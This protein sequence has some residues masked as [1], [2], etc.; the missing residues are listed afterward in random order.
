MVELQEDY[1]P[2]LRKLWGAIVKAHTILP[3][4]CGVTLY[5]IQTS[6]MGVFQDLLTRKAFTKLSKS[7]IINYLL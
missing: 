2:Y 5:L 3:L 4:L 6:I 7:S 1:P